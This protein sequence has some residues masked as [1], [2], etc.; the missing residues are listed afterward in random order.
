M[1]APPPPMQ[2]PVLGFVFGLVGGILILLSGVLFL[3]SPFSFFIGIFSILG[4][5]FGALVIA[6]S[7]VLY[8]DP[9]HHVGWGVMVLVFSVLSIVNFGGFIAGMALGIVGGA[10]GIAWRPGGGPSAAGGYFTGPF[11]VPVMPWRMCMGCGR[12]IPW[13]Y[14]V[15]PLCGTQAPVAAWAPHVPAAPPAADAP[16]AAPPFI[17][18]AP[19]PSGPAPPAPLAPSTVKAPCPTCDA[20]AEWLPMYKRWYCATETRYF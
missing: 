16:V 18:P 10:L 6:S 12:W 14:N 8:G 7:I 5:V 19:P 13:V 17:A 11:G 1:S 9:P 2:R 20:D 3:T 15:C 4:I